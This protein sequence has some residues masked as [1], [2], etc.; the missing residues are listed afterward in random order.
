[1]RNLIKVLILLISLCGYSQEQ[2]TQVNVSDFYREGDLAYLH[3]KKEKYIII[4]MT[5]FDD[6][7]NVAKEMVLNGI[8]YRLKK[9]FKIKNL[10]STSTI[11]SLEYWS[12]INDD[13]ILMD[14]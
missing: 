11:H 13:I 14:K 9:V 1:M 12:S 2:K 7:K 5:H 6:E 10:E 8:E 4:Q 3:I